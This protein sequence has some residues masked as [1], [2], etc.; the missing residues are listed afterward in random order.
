VFQLKLP[1]NSFF[2]MFLS[3]YSGSVGA[4]DAPQF[5]RGCGPVARW[6]TGPPGWLT[7]LVGNQHLEVVEAHPR[8]THLV[9]PTPGAGN[10]DVGTTSQCLELGARFDSSRSNAGSS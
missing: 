7:G 1:T 3:S 2:D 9:E 4:A 6:I 10:D 5:T 8:L